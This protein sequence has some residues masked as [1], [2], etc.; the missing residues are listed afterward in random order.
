MMLIIRCAYKSAVK[1]LQTPVC[2]GSLLAV[3]NNYQQSSVS[4]SLAKVSLLSVST[5]L[6]L[7]AKALPGM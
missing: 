7:A 4:L 6:K 1:S 5:D 2:L 3:Q